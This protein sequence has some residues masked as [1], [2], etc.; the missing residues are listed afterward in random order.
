MAPA[1]VRENTRGAATPPPVPVVPPPGCEAP[2]SP[3]MRAATK[4]LR[5]SSAVCARCRAKASGELPIIELEAGPDDG[6]DAACEAWKAK[7]GRCGCDGCWPC[8]TAAPAGEPCPIGMLDDTGMPM[9][10]GPP[11]ESPVRRTKLLRSISGIT[12]CAI[13]KALALS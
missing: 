9:D 8:G 11:P 7:P 4:R 3:P 10:D 6:T 13:R 12:P 1:K 2:A 5:L